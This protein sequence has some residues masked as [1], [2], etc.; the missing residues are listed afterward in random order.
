MQMSVSLTYEPALEPLR[1]SVKWLFCPDPNGSGQAL[2]GS[3]DRYV[4]LWSHLHAPPFTSPT[5]FA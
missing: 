2:S 3:R 4:R 5:V 1:I